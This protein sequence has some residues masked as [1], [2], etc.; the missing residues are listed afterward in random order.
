VRLN[1]VPNAAP[2]TYMVGQR[3]Y[4]AVT[5]GYGGGQIATFPQLV[6]DIPFPVAGSSTIWVFALPE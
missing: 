6:P 5:M 4:V 1:D 2:I 3:Q